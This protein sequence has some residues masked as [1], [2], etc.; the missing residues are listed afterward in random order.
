MTTLFKSPLLLATL[1]GAATLAATPLA[2]RDAPGFEARTVSPAIGARAELTPY[3]QCVPYARQVS[4]VQI[5][6]DARTWWDQAQGRYA[7]G[8][9]PKKAR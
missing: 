5:Y 9:V 7:T 8:T 1:A 2:A 3:L 4:G 6:G